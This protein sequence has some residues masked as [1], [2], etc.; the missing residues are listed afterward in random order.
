MAS[1]RVDIFKFTGRWVRLGG[2]AKVADYLA[3]ESDDLII[4]GQTILDILKTPR[5]T[6]EIISEL[7]SDAYLET[8]D[9]EIMEVLDILEDGDIIR[10]EKCLPE[11]TKPPSSS[12]KPTDQVKW[13]LTNV[14]PCSVYLGMIVADPG[15]YLEAII[16]GLQTGYL[17]Q[18]GLYKWTLGY[19]GNTDCTNATRMF[20]MSLEKLKLDGM[21]RR[22]NDI[23]AHNHDSSHQQPVHQ[24]ALGPVHPSTAQQHCSTASMIAP[25]GGYTT[26]QPT[27]ST[28]R[29]RAKFSN[30][31]V[32]DISFG[33]ADILSIPRQQS[34]IATT[35]HQVLTQDH[36]NIADSITARQTGW[37]L[38]T[39]N[40]GS[41]EIQKLD[42]KTGFSSD[43]AAREFVKYQASLGNSPVMSKALR[44]TTHPI[45][46]FKTD[47][48]KLRWDLLPMGPIQEAV[49]ALTIGLQKYPA[50]N[51][52]K[53][54]GFNYSRVYSSLMRHLTSWSMGED[55]DQESKLNHLS[56]VLCN[57][58]FLLEYQLRGIGNDDRQKY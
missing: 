45:K 36:W 16:T 15:S 54:N 24:G 47:Q 53:D 44:L 51:W 27:A 43:D 48:G 9:T 19:V 42:E 32:E 38:F 35:T 14:M 58:M 46:A 30:G 21:I 25:S 23:A 40:D 28:V 6:K 57:V 13:E 5:T 31:S 18:L 1:H 8:S 3:K 20:S 26:K 29:G 34:T 11:K 33:T 56:H 7:A 37:D 55:Y 10:Q 22:V 52:K 50:D 17:S 39:T 41:L 49:K 4:L 12:T 2:P